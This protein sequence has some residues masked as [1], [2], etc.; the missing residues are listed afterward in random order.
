MSKISIAIVIPVYNVENYVKQTLD[1]VKKQISNPDEVIVINDGSTDNSGNIITS[2]NH[3]E[4][5]RII[6]KNNQGLGLTRNY[7]RTIAK[8]EYI[9]FLDSDDIIKNNLV[10]RLREL[11]QK[12]NKP[13]MILFSGETFSDEKLV[14]NNF[15]GEFL[16][17]KGLLTTNVEFETFSRM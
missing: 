9:Y 10:L 2:Y 12:N 15:S 7:G 6:H 8:S 14:T 11:I 1:S 13:D 3:L 17:S 4:N 5:W 16:T